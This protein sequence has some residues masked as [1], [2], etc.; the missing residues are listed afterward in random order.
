LNLGRPIENKAAMDKVL[1]NEVEIDEYN[2]FICF[3]D[4]DRKPSAQTCF[5]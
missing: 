3:A 1:D 2:C 4:G 5:Q